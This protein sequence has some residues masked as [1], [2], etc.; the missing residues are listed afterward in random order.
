MIP[1]VRST[2]LSKEEISAMDVKP[3]LQ[4]YLGEEA[5]ATVLLHNASDKLDFEDY[6]AMADCARWTK[7]IS[8]RRMA[9]DLVI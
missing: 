3:G 6:V 7:V 9:S 4:E 1:G 8:E 5:P 2:L